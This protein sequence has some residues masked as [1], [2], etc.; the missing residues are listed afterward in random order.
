MKLV[1]QLQS[2]NGFNNIHQISMYRTRIILRS[3]AG[4][5]MVI[6]VTVS[7]STYLRHDFR[8]GIFE[9]FCETVALH[10]AFAYS[11]GQR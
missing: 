6:L 3:V 8:I 7:S 2:N 1:M 10:T 11:V 5:R 4:R 9:R